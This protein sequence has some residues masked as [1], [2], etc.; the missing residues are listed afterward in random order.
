[1]ANTSILLTECILW[2]AVE[3][4]VEKESTHRAAG[5]QIYVGKIA[6]IFTKRAGVVYL[7]AVNNMFDFETLFYFPQTFARAL[8][9]PPAAFSCIRLKHPLDVEH[10]LDIKIPRQGE[11]SRGPL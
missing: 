7:P 8:K 3:T 9:W 5:A 2:R 11:R 4:Q 1:M 10:Y 6:R